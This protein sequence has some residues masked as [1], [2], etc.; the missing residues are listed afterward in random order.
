MSI[1]DTV[2][3]VLPPTSRAMVNLAEDLAS[4]IDTVS[5]D[6]SD[7]THR[8]SAKI[9]DVSGLVEHS[10]DDLR[11]ELI[12]NAN[13]N[14]ARTLDMARQYTMLE[15]QL[16]YC[17]L[18]YSSKLADSPSDILIAGYYGAENYGDE[19]MLD[20]ILQ[21]VPENQ[22]HRIAVLLWDNFSYPQDAIDARI[23]KLHYPNSTWDLE[24]LARHF[25]TLVWGGGAIIDDNQ[26]T[27]DPLNINT[28]N[29]FIRLSSQM[30]ALNKKVYCL[31]LS[32]NAEIN[33]ST[34]TKMLDKVASEASIF[35]LRDPHSL[36]TLRSA[37]VDV[38]S[39][40]L[41]H[42][43]A[44]SNIELEALSKT[45]SE[46]SGNLRVGLVFLS[47][48]EYEEKYTCVIKKTVETLKNIDADYELVL[49]PFYNE[50]N[51]DS[52]N[53]A[54]LADNAQH[55]SHVS[56]APYPRDPAGFEFDSLDL[57]ISYKYHSSLISLVQGTPTVIVYDSNHP[58]YINKMMYLA[59]L[60]G[61]EKSCLS[62][63]DFE[64]RVAEVVCESLKNPIQ[65]AD[66]TEFL[67]EQQC[68]LAKSLA[69]ILS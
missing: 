36:E 39:I 52:R 10:A 24:Y 58:H 9:E 67:K 59:T 56:V 69:T 43:L 15:K 7:S 41:C 27:D 28:G 25:S 32:A 55:R 17:N 62:A 34:Y 66:M 33:S 38:N 26:Y 45:H 31:G 54:K 5:S 6:L 12:D 60:F 30:L 63:S 68:W 47:A 51:Y 16:R 3:P 23:T 37:G 40:E 4:R 19:L 22:L 49:I 2:R 46:H 8:I 35:S 48:E 21:A 64:A 13:R 65:P 14:G 42:D 18:E 44:F 50:N 53:L 29:L 57:L 61:Y 11:K 1:K 20:T